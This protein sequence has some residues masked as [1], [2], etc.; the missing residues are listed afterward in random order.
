MVFSALTY[1][2]RRYEKQKGGGVLKLLGNFPPPPRIQR[3]GGERKKTFN[4]CG[5]KML[6]SFKK[7]FGFVFKFFLVEC[8][9]PLNHSVL[10]L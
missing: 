5:E 3:E 1:F 7:E 8:N 2:I 6:Y 10:G 9:V 4:I